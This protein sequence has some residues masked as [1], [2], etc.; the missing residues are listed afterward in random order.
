MPKITFGR[1]I[2]ENQTLYSALN[3]D[4]FRKLKESK[5]YLGSDE[6]SVLQEIANI[7]RKIKPTWGI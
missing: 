2:N 4:E 5:K 6:I 1:Q 3:E 7:K